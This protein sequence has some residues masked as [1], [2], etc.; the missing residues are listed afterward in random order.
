MSRTKELEVLRNE[1]KVVTEDIIK[2]LG[3]RLELTRKIG[4]IKASLGMAIIDPKVENELRKS[5]SALCKKN[6]VNE[7]FGLLILDLLIKESIKEEKR[8]TK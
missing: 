2:L 5:V 3:K 7:L 1:V 6:G 8:Q 4:K